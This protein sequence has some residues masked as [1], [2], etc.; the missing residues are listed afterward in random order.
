MKRRGL[1]TI[2]VSVTRKSG[3]LNVQFTGSDQ[4]VKQASQ[5]LA[6]WT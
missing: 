5:I 4:E 3:R 1:T 2:R 6:E